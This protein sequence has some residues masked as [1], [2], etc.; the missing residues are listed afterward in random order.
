MDSAA[1]LK[2]LVRAWP[3]LHCDSGV[4]MCPPACGHEAVSHH[5][6]RVHSTPLST[7]CAEARRFRHQRL[8]KRAIA[9]CRSS[10]D[11]ASTPPLSTDEQKLP[12]ALVLAASPYP[13]AV[14]LERTVHRRMHP[15]RIAVYHDEPHEGA[16]CRH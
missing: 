16:T 3:T 15:K 2:R 8:F 12:D 7:R 6:S 5:S 1:E 14:S 9:G 11:T 4:H 10:V 13:V